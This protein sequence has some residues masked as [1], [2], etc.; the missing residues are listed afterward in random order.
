MCQCDPAVTVVDSSAL[1]SAHSHSGLTRLA[2]AGTVPVPVTIHDAGSLEGQ[3]DESSR[4]RSQREC[5]AT[6]SRCACA[7][8]GCAHCTVQRLRFSPGP[9]ISLLPAITGPLVQPGSHEHGHS[10]FSSPSR[11]LRHNAVQRR[12]CGRCGCV[13]GC[14]SDQPHTLSQSLPSRTAA[15]CGPCIAARIRIR[16][17]AALLASPPRLV[18]SAPAAARTAAVTRTSARR[19]HD[20]GQGAAARAGAVC[21]HRRRAA[22]GERR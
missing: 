15:H 2:Q 16:G 9:P 20:P 14:V 21:G 13:C 11:T 8:T 17:A 10:F 19:Q 22:R 18:R 6:H 7:G 5:D 12:C 4:S 3:Q 1:P